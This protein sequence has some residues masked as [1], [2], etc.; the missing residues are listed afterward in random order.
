M[1]EQSQQLQPHPRTA[2]NLRLALNQNKVQWCL[3]NPSPTPIVLYFQ[4]QNEFPENEHAHRRKMWQTSNAQKFDNEGHLLA[5]I[6]NMLP[7][8]R[9]DHREVLSKC[10]SLCVPCTSGDNDNISSR[11]HSDRSEI[12]GGATLG[13]SNSSGE[14]PQSLLDRFLRRRP[15]PSL[16]SSPRVGERPA[17]AAAPTALLRPTRHVYKVDSVNLE[18]YVRLNQYKLTGE[19]GQCYVQDETPHAAISMRVVS[20]MLNGR[21]AMPTRVNPLRL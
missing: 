10:P 5:P 4:D 12:S 6:D 11:A 7:S 13:K 19:I 20:K 15:A 2:E 17:T 16:P 8:Q 9:S 1:G 21:N 3:L 14:Q 18:G